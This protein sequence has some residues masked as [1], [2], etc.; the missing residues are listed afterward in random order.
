MGTYAA[1]IMLV[2]LIAFP[3]LFALV[4]S[5]QSTS[6]ILTA[7]YRLW[8]GHSGPSNYWRAWSEFNLGRLMF[9]SFVMTVIGTV[10]KVC[11]SLLGALAFVYFDFPGKNL[12]FFAVLATLMLPLPV[13]L[14]PLFDLVSRLGWGNT[15][16]AITVPYMASATGV[17]LFRQH[18]LSVPSSI[19]E[20]ARIDG[21]GPM[22]FLWYILIPMSRNVIGALIVIQ[23]IYLWNEYLWPLVVT[24]SPSMQV[25]QIGLK[26]MIGGQSYT[27]WGVVMAGAIVALLP[28]LL[29]LL[30]LHDHFMRGV[31]LTQEK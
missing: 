18:F 2:V 30:L 24:S 1:L 10:G 15:Y 9:N 6:E 26:Q 17:F 16:L 31:G 19:A 5:T 11:T 13:I 8:P 7:P 14:V 21:V 4:K 12:L 27:D 22:R 29:M 25:I 28:P 20:A 3:V 23:F